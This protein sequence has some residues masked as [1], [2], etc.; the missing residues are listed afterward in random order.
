MLK[1]SIQLSCFGGNGGGSA[2]RGAPGP[3]P[4]TPA[5]AITGGVE[6]DKRLEAVVIADLESRLCTPGS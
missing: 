1:E 2:D 3:D 6:V 5:I 4:E